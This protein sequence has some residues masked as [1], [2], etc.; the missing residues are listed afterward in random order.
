MYDEDNEFAK[1]DGDVIIDAYASETE[2]VEA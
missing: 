2:Q 1:A